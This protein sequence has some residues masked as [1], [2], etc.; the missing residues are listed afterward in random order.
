MSATAKQLSEKQ[1]NRSDLCLSLPSLKQNNDLKKKLCIH[2]LYS[3]TS[4]TSHED[5]V[6]FRTF[7][8]TAQ[9]FMIHAINIY[10]WYYKH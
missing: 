6:I 5:C 10:H 8:K 4:S 1:N 3:Q 2:T 7:A 9:R